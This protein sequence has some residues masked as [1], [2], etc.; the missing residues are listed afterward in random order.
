VDALDLE[1]PAGT[2]FGF[3]GPYGAGKTTTIR[4]LLGLLEPTS[5]R[6]SVLG[7]DTRSQGGMIR[8][9]SGALLEHHGLYERLS[10]EDNLAFYARVWRMARAERDERIKG[11]LEP[12]GL[13]ERR[14]EPVG[15][16]SRGMKQKLAVAR[17]L[18]HEPS[19]LFLDEPTAGLD[20]LAAATLR[21]EL[22]TLVRREGVTVFLT[23]HNLAEAERLCSRVAVIKQG[24]LLAVG[25]PDQLKARTATRA[26]ITGRGFGDATLALLRG[27]PGVVGADL[28]NGRILLE[29]TES[30]DTAPLVTLIVQSGGS[31]E[32]VRKDR[33]SLEDVFLTLMEEER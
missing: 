24:R 9:K 27:R 2:V 29:L 21:D 20:P 8:E 28:R 25:H 13:W 14:R 32:E 22:G 33:G 4:L 10:A 7:F 15:R 19:L 30:A 6:A 16:W 18:L 1:I 23:T 3:L 31:V 5:G 17:A 12:L 11:L 26:E